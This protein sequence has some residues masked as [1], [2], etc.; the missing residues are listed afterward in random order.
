MVIVLLIQL[1]I[2]CMSI[3]SCIT[4]YTEQIRDLFYHITLQALKESTSDQQIEIA[5]NLKKY[6]GCMHNSLG[7][8]QADR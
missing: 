8:S 1:F 7:G 6:V 5:F 4:D 3:T 2:P